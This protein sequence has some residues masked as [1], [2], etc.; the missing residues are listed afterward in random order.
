MSGSCRRAGLQ[1]GGVPSTA[2]AIVVRPDSA[3][4][5]S[6]IS[7]RSSSCSPRPASTTRLVVHF[8]ERP[9]RRAPRTSLPRFSSTARARPSWSPRLP[10]RPRPQGNV[11][12]LGSSGRNTARRLRHQLI[13]DH[14]QRSPQRDPPSPG[15]GRRRRGALNSSA[16]A[17]KSGARGRGRPPRP[18][19]RVPDRQRHRPCRDSVAGG[20]HLLGWYEAVGRAVHAALSLGR[21]PN[22][23][24]DAEFSLLEAYLIDF[25]GDLY[26]ERAKVLFVNAF[27]RGEIRVGGGAYRAIEGR[28]RDPPAA[29]LSS[30]KPIARRAA[31]RYGDRS[32]RPVRDDAGWCGACVGERVHPHA[33]AM[34]CRHEN[35]AGRVQLQVPDRNV[36]YARA[37]SRERT[38]ATRGPLGDE[39]PVVHADDQR[40][41]TQHHRHGGRVGEVPRDVGEVLAPV[42]R[43]EQVT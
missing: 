27:G 4:S 30:R 26:G 23:Y 11:P 33:A 14:A 38:D 35:L 9:R 20:R 43:D 3:P 19:P 31:A 13:E 1:V 29:R 32:S 8:D 7:S 18:G 34:G 5:C 22:V 6:P 39:H 21:R 41:V 15:R 24:D 37:Q 28:R 40:V 42:V 16:A 10:L 36:R 17:W 25:D 2:P 12:L